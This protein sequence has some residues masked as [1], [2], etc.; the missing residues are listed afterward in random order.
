MPFVRPTVPEIVGQAAVSRRFV[1][2]KERWSTK[3]DRLLW[4]GSDLDEARKRF[5][6]AVKHR[7]RIRLTIRQRMRVLAA[8]RTYS[9]GLY[10]A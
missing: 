8:C 10:E 3:V 7:P 9:N 6:A 1:T 5:D 2:M 4:A